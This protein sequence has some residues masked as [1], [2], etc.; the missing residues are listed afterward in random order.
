[1]SSEPNKA[2]VQAYVD[3]VNAADIEREMTMVTP[4][5]AIHTPVPGIG[6]GIESMRGLMTIYHGAF[7]EQRVDVRDMIVDG[8]KVV[9]LHTHHLTQGGPF[10]GAPASGKHAV[11][12]GIEIFR[13][14]D[15]RI[16]EFWHADD[17]VGLFQQLELTP[18]G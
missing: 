10:M 15:G 17:F 12:D 18:P 1:M 11:I 5:I 3:A 14:A 7:T 6:N 8:D 13:I 2:V 9:L 4:D 16:A